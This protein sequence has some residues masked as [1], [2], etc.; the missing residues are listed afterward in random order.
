MDRF[1]VERFKSLENSIIALRELNKS[2]TLRKEVKLRNLT[3]IEEYSDEIVE[4]LLVETG[5]IEYKHFSGHK[6]V[7]CN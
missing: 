5:G 3:K 6:E 4:R 1:D 2:E 7:V